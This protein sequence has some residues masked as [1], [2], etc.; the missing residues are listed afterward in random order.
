MVVAEQE[1]VERQGRPI[2]EV[3]GVPDAGPLLARERGEQA[4][5]D[6]DSVG[7]VGRLEREI[8][9]IAARAGDVVEPVERDVS[10][11]VR[12]RAEASCQSELFEQVEPLAAA[13]RL[14]VAHDGEKR[15]I[16]RL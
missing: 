11:D 10:D 14:V 16:S 6:E 15:H 13:G 8:E 12:G 7:G 5:G 3:L 2:E 4:V 1:G 9:A